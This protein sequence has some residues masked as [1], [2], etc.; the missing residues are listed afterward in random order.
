LLADP[1]VARAQRAAKA[2][3]KKEADDS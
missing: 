2:K 1:K 3:E